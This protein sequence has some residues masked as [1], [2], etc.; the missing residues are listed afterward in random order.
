MILFKRTIKRTFIIG[1]LIVGFILPIGL[2]GQAQSNALAIDNLLPEIWN[3]PEAWKPPVRTG[4]LPGNRQPGGVRGCNL[5]LTAL[6]PDLEKDRAILTDSA[7][8]SFFW[9]IVRFDNDDDWQL[10]FSLEDQEGNQVYA[11]EY[12]LAKAE[13]N[14]FISEVM[15]LDLPAYAAFTPLERNKEYK[16]TIKPICNEQPLRIAYGYIYRVNDLS[17]QL[18]ES[19]NQAPL[20]EKLAIY[21]RNGFWPETLATLYDLGRS[22]P[23][24]SPQLE[25]QLQHAWIKLLNSVGLNQVARDLSSIYAQSSI[26]RT[27]NQ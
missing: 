8:P 13:R 3:P 2:S 25:P 5:R 26:Q 6:A 15:R 18:R 23:P 10:Q 27:T 11:T 4:D 21:A 1:L 14:G 16:W 17:L 19:L 9:H 20:Q 24:D 12:K 22:T 7:Y